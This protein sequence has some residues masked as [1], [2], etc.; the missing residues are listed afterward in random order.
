MVK[1]KGRVGLVV[2]TLCLAAAAFKAYAYDNG[3]FQI[4]NT[5]YEDINIAK[6]VKFSMEQEFRF[7]ENAHELY[8][9][10]YDWG[11]V[12]GFDKM[13]DL[14]FF[15]RLVLEKFQHKWRE[16]DQ[17]N[18]NATVKLDLWKF[19]FDDRNRLE[20]RHFRYK[21]DSMRYRNKFTLKLPFDFAKM[22]I[23]I[24]PYSS[25]EIFISSDSTGFDEN[26]FSSGSEFDLT[27]YVKADIYYM[28]K[29][30]RVRGSK[31]NSAN[32]LGTKVKIA[33]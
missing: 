2:L 28:F 33:F 16:E 21:D 22:K 12:Y 11:F 25:D 7:G 4:W 5:D 30:N 20:Y 10:H 27:K 3:D 29:S 23:R 32:V 18:V 17:P 19:K 15:Y 1:A 31:W 8:Y 13:L 9:Q 14:G 26:R 6:D 24:S